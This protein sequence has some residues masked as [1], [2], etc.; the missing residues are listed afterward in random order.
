MWPRVRPTNTVK[1]EIKGCPWILMTLYSVLSVLGVTRK[2]LSLLGSSYCSTLQPRLSPT[3]NPSAILYKSLLFTSLFIC[4]LRYASRPAHPVRHFSFG[5]QMVVFCLAN[6]QQGSHWTFV[7]PRRTAESLKV[8]PVA[9]LNSKICRVEGPKN[10]TQVHRP[11]FKTTNIVF[12]PNDAPRKVA[13]CLLIYSLYLLLLLLYVN[14]LF[15]CVI[16]Y[17]Y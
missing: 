10:G 14:K 11:K 8:W 2:F 13:H 17:F 4:S 15:R 16:L 7:P 12:S 3:G 5:P 9:W 6:P 1:D